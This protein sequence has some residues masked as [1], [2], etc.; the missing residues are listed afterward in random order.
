MDLIDPIVRAKNDEA[1]SYSLVAAAR[2][3]F[4]GVF[5]TLRVDARYLARSEI[6]N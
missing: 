1:S 2:S 6:H 5:G 4:D 3:D